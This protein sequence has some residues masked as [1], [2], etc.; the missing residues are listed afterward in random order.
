M[1]EERLAWARHELE[2]VHHYDYHI[3]NDH[4]DTAYHVLKS[5]FIAFLF[6]MPKNKVSHT[7]LL[8]HYCIV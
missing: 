8:A 2:M 4:F 1:I 7:H 5:I 3:V 6:H